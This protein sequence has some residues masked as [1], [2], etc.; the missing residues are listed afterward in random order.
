MFLDPVKIRM[1]PMEQANCTEIV[2]SIVL[3]W[4]EPGGG[5]NF[6]GRK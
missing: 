5:E 1:H 4:T 2:P 3:L 6:P